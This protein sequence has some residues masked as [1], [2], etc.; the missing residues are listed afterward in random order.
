M[1]VGY[2]QDAFVMHTGY[3][4]DAFIRSENKSYS[5]NSLLCCKSDT[6]EPGYSSVSSI[7]II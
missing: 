3:I 4:Q 1:H 6:S 5:I 7:L 2:I